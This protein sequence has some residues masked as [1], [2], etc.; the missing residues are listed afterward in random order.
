MKGLLPPPPLL[1]LLPQLRCEIWTR[2]FREWAGGE[3][4]SSGVL[5]IRTVSTRENAQTDSR[6]TP[7][8]R[9][10]ALLSLSNDGSLFCQP[11]SFNW[12]VRNSHPFDVQWGAG[13]QVERKTVPFY[14]RVCNV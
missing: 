10:P 2:K 9:L 6:L 3:V 12:A 7:N 13:Q 14:V 11:C 1:L 4:R 5:K 8:S